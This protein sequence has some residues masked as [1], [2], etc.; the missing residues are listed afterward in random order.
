MALGR[1][2][3]VAGVAAVTAVEMAALAFWLGVVEGGVAPGLPAVVGVAVLFAGLVVEGALEY[4]TVNGASPPPGRT[5]VAVAFSETALWGA[6]LLAANWV[7]GHVGVAAA[8]AGLFVLLVPQHT[9]EDNALRGADPFSDAVD[10]G[11][12]GFSLVEA[13]AAG[14][15][16]AFVRLDAGTVALLQGDGAFT[17]ASVALPALT[18]FHVVV[19]LPSQIEAGAAVGF[20]ALGVLLFVEHLL[21]VDFARR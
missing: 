2:G 12:L 1:Y 10:V 8:S 11:T 3:R 9:V 4:V 5:L 6:W 18:E 21:A 20:A 13:S 14:V 15:W 7:G 17:A 19:E 16:L